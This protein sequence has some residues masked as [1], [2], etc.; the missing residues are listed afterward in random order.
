MGLP[1]PARADEGALLEVEHRPDDA[2]HVLVPVVDVLGDAAGDEVRDVV[3]V[4]VGVQVVLLDVVLV[5]QGAGRDDPLLL[6]ADGDL[7]A[8]PF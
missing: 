4:V 1:R 3:E 8:R 2:L 7:A 5:E 6:E